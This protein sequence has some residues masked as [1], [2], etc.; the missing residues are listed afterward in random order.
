[1]QLLGNLGIDLHLLI[2]QIIN[3]LLLLFLLNKYLY[4]PLIRRIEKDENDISG[5]HN[6][7][8]K[9]QKEK[10][11]FQK[12]KEESLSKLKTQSQD[13]IKEATQIANEIRQ[14]AELRG[15]EEIKRVKEQ[16]SSQIT[17]QEKNK[18]LLEMKQMQES[19]FSTLFNTL[20]TTF[21]QKR[22]TDIQQMFFSQLLDDLN[23]A[24]FNLQQ[25][26][27]PLKFEYSVPI[28]DDEQKSLS[29]LL[30]KKLQVAEITI[31]Y[32]KS[33]SLL[34]GVKLEAAGQLFLHDLREE[35]QK[36]LVS[37]PTK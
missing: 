18:K 29:E 15:E 36:T 33:D 30:S 24:E 23:K 5:L 10:D 34:C 17:N 28:S 37:S 6:E 13:V 4:K 12:E 11:A 20:Q 16:F 26:T 27:F 2:A 9:F 3:F 25:R 32:Q 14:K 8:S 19:I 22:K 35:L 7:K 1:M 21:D 31:D